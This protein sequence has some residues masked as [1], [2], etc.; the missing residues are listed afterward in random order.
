MADDDARFAELEPHPERGPDTEEW[1]IL[2]GPAI[3]AAAGLLL[4]IV[5]LV[6]V[7]QAHAI[8]NASS[9][10]TR[11]GLPGL[12]AILGFVVG[13]LLS[14]PGRGGAHAPVR[15]RRDP[16]RNRAAAGEHPDLVERR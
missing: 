7:D 1:Q 3:G 4:G 16:H 11:F 5:V 10:V 14:A 2:A 13:M 9:P 15:D 6:M 12:G 8:G